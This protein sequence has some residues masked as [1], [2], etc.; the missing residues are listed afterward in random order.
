MRQEKR[1][2]Q[3]NNRNGDRNEDSIKFPRDRYR[4]KIERMRKEKKKKRNEKRKCR[5]KSKWGKSM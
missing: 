3:M 2:D 1:K 5:Q 4:K